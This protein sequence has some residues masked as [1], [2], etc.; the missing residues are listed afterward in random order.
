MAV[1]S[2]LSLSF[3]PLSLTL[4]G[5][6]TSP[7]H[8]AS[9]RHMCTHAVV[10]SFKA[11]YLGVRVWLVPDLEEAVP[12]AGADRHAVLGDAQTA[13]PVV[14][15]GQHSCGGRVGRRS[16]RRQGIMIYVYTNGGKM[17]HRPGT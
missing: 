9:Q 10:P 2:R 16:G 8:A 7:R 12:G 14:V 1:G 4:S 13:D 5:R 6:A 17:C 15:A 11:S 3:S